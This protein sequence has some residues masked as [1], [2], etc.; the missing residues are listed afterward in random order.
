MS[1]KPDDQSI[2]TKIKEG[3]REFL[4]C[5]FQRKRFNNHNFYKICVF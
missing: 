5:L 3:K 4:D 1:N 2:E